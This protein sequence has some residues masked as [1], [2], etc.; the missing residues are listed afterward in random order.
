MSLAQRLALLAATLAVVLVAGTTELEL[1]WTA[2][3]RMNDL[4]RESEALAETWAIYLTRL[5][6]TM[7]PDTLAR[8]LT[9]WPSQHVTVTS[10]EL[11]AV[12]RRGRLSWVAGSDSTPDVPMPQ[13]SLAAVTRTRQVWRLP[14]PEPTWQVA[15]PLGTPGARAVLHI[16]VSTRALLAQARVERQRAY[17]LAAAVA[18]LLALAF[19]WI[20]RHWIGRPFARLEAA[21]QRTQQ[22]GPGGAA[23]TLDD[24]GPTEFRRLARRYAEVES[25]LALREQEAQARA[26]LQALDERARTLERLTLAQQAEAE[27]AHEIGTPLNTVSGHLQLLR[28]D[29]AGADDTDRTIPRVEAV[30]EQVRRLSGI[31]RAKLDQGGLLQLDPHPTD[32][33]VVARRSLDFMRPAMEKSRIAGA[34]DG[35]DDGSVV[36]TADPGLVEQILLNLIKNAVEAMPGGGQVRIRAGQTNGQVTLE[37]ADS[38]PGLADAVRGS[39]FQPFASTKGVAGTGLG[40]VV[41]RRLARAMGGELELRPSER[42]ACWRLTLPG[43]ATNGREPAR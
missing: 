34:V 4:R 20:T 1:R 3:S 40:L 41:S 11:F 29:L 7:H 32:V 19:W 25:A 43:L 26:E 35:G 30:L 9:N 23:L 15:V 42:G 17:A 28:E 12:D 6:P 37:V 27:F 36:A 22:Q 18:A 39:L 8:A 14:D 2:A 10:A 33:R 31:V 13:D 21:M 16:E 5:S 24:I 38:G